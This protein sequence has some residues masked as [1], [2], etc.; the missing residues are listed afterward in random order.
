M[1]SLGFILIC[2]TPM[3][4][5]HFY[6]FLVITFSM[7]LWQYNKYKYISLFLWPFQAY[8]M[9]FC[10]PFNNI[11]GRSL[12]ISMQGAFSFFIVVFDANIIVYLS[13]P[14][15][16]SSPSVLSTLSKLRPNVKRNYRCKKSQNCLKLSVAIL[17]FKMEIN[18]VLN[19]NLNSLT[20]NSWCRIIK[21]PLYRKTFRGLFTDCASW[22]LLVWFMEQIS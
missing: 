5:N 13:S 6:L 9:L 3:V 19:W 15:P 21:K 10:F 14:M 17:P 8:K 11:Y 2:L 16:P 1:V 12:Q 20:F 18:S 7:S 22:G 4:R